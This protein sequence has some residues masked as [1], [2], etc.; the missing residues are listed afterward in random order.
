MTPHQG[1]AFGLV[2]GRDGTTGRNGLEQA[3]ELREVMPFRIE[4]EA[5][6]LG[7]NF[8]SAG[9]W[10]EFAVRDGRLITGQQQ[11]SGRATA[12]LVIET[13]GR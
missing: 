8:V 4:D 3:P 10:R 13:L 1:P 2:A 6:K 9:A 7:A 11:Y 5:R 12:R